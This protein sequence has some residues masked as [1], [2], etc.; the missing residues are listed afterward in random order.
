MIVPFIMSL[1]VQDDALYTWYFYKFLDEAKKYGWPMIA[2][3]IYFTKPSVFAAEGRWETSDTPTGDANRKRFEFERPE[4]ADLKKIQPYMIPTELDDQLIKEKGTR[5]AAYCY[6]LKERWGKLEEL[7]CS[8]IEDIQAK[9]TEKIDAI[10]T[11]CHYPSLSAVAEKYQIP[12]YHMEMGPL[13]EPCY[14]IRTAYFDRNNLFGAAS[15]EE[16]YQSFC[17]DIKKNPVPILTAD[18]ILALMLKK[19]RLP[20]LSLRPM[21]PPYK[22]GVALGA[23]YWPIF[24]CKESMLDSELLYQVRKRIPMERVLLRKHP[25]DFY[26]AQYAA[27][28]KYMDKSANPVE[29]IIQCKKV[30]TLSSNVA[31]EAMLW[32]KEIYILF[33]CPASCA[34]H[35]TLDSTQTNVKVDDTFLSFF[36]FSYLIP[37][38]FMTDQVYIQWRN[39]NPPEHEIYN[40]HLYFYL[41]QKGLS[42]KILEYKGK[43]RLIKMMELQGLDLTTEGHNLADQMNFRIKEDF[44]STEEKD[45]AELK[46]GYDKLM[47]QYR[48][49]NEKMMTLQL[50]YNEVMKSKAW[51]LIALY[52]KLRQVLKI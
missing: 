14:F 46:N 43:Q 39:T 28:G 44:W 12:V 34:A 7:L 35:R 48:D 3:E 17:E 36:V 29:F 42:S 22:M 24:N 32:G 18:E 21:K 4:D 13:R 23:A 33:D 37:Y 50:H 26:K 10:C 38:C 1:S 40:K 15:T 2:Q 51:K 9:N 41:E 19:E 11:L 30:C 27:Y 8:F 20:Y 47:H 52:R 31:V 5:N 16:R 25:G 6:I 45:L 49:L